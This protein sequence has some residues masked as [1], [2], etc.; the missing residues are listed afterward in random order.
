MTDED[1]VEELGTQI[2]EVSHIALT[3]QQ[4]VRRAAWFTIIGSGFWLVSVSSSCL[5]P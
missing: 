5:T 2:V 3:K 1:W 4:L